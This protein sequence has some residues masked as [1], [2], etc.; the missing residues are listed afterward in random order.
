MKYIYPI[1]CIIFFVSCS[2]SENDLFHPKVENYPYYNS[3]VDIEIV[4]RKYDDSV[5]EEINYSGIP[6][7]EKSIFKKK[8]SI[9]FLDSVV[10]PDG[11]I[12]YSQFESLNDS[13]IVFNDVFTNNLSLY[14]YDFDNWET[15]AEQGRGPGQIM[16]SSDLIVKDNQVITSH[17][18][19]RVNFFNC[20]KKTCEYDK[21]LVL[22]KIQPESIQIHNG[23]IVAMGTNSFLAQGFSSEVNESD[24]ISIHKYNESGDYINSFGE[25]YNINGHWMLMRPFSEGKIRINK[26]GKL[27]QSY[28]LLPYLYVFSNDILDKKIVFRG[29][30]ISKR[31]YITE[32]QELFVNFD[33][34]SMIQDVKIIDNTKLLVTIR[35]LANRNVLT[36]IVD[37]EESKDFYLIDMEDYSSYYMGNFSIDNENLWFT[38]KHVVFSKNNFLHIYK[39]KLE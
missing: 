12:N 37:W 5:E 25:F 18:D 1:F 27:F 2:S 4:E 19:S 28:K 9:S 24:L 20:F 29:F 36:D 14:G 8:F 26:E 30:N 6:H 15:I 13:L 32:T 17:K 21:T 22:D 31:K 33:D 35:H 16:F 11:E 10:I 39:Y 34:W 23:E 7:Y 38:S 3:K